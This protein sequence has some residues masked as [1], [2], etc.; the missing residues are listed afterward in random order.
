MFLRDKNILSGTYFSRKVFNNC[1]FWKIA[2]LYIF[3]FNTSCKF[4]WI[5]SQFL[6][7]MMQP[8]MAFVGNIGYVAV[9]IFG[10]YP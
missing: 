10:G 8:I 9:A 3:K 4:I 6:S 5:S 7:G 1:L 2:K